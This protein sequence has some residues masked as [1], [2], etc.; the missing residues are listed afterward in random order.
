[1]TERPKLIAPSIL[2]ADMAALGQADPDR[3]LE[4]FAQAGAAVLTVQAEACTHLYRTLE[5]IRALGIRSGVSINPATPVASIEHVL[6]CADLV[7]VMTVEPGFGGQRFIP[8]MLDK[9]RRVKQLVD[10][11]HLVVDI[12]VDGGIKEDT[13]GPAAQAGANVFVS[14]SGVFGQGDVAAALRG[15]KAALDKT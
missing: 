2:S 13:I 8:S 7:L 4:A 10:E 15:L 3:Y 1:M 12:Q 11:R 6:E 14:G 9:V 5:Q